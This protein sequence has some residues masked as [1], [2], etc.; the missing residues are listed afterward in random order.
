ME[1]LLE[2][3]APSLL[4]HRLSSFNEAVQEEA[5]AVYNVLAIFENCVE[6]KPEVAELLFEKTKVREA[7][8]PPCLDLAA[9]LR[10]WASDGCRCPLSWTLLVFW[11]VLPLSRPCR[12]P[13]GR[14]WTAFHAC[15]LGLAGFPSPNPPLSSPGPPTTPTTHTAPQVAAGAAARQGGRLQQAVRFRGTGHPGAAVRCSALP[16]VELLAGSAARRPPASRNTGAADASASTVCA[17]PRSARPSVLLLCFGCKL[18][19]GFPQAL[20]PRPVCLP[21]DGLHS[22]LS[23]FL[24]RGQQAQDGRHQRDRQRAAGHRAVPQ[25]VPARTAARTALTG[26]WHHSCGTRMQPA[27]ARLLH[28]PAKRAPHQQQRRSN[29]RP[30][31]LQLAATR[32][33]WPCHPAAPR[34]LGLVR[35]VLLTLP[36]GLPQGP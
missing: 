9:R 33:F 20:P 34:R 16:R 23:S 17:R 7:R 26:G 11:P 12:M 27:P 2:H 1:S 10:L 31:P 21:P 5:A 3:D 19:C 35:G 14:Y 8:A 32:S 15:K 25:Q 22:F 24:C 36:P 29:P 28:Q 13:G 18:V 30:Q 6:V 4:V